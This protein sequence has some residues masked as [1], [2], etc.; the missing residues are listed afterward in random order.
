MRGDL[1]QVAQL[2]TADPA[3]ANFTTDNGITPLHCAAG[4]GYIDVVRFLV[5]R[6]GA[7]V[8]CKAV[9]GATSLHFA[10]LNRHTEIARFLLRHGADADASTRQHQRPIHLAVRWTSNPDMRDVIAL[11]IQC[12]AQI[13]VYVNIAIA[14]IDDAI[15]AI[16]PQGVSSQAYLPNDLL[17]SAMLR[18]SLQ[19]VEHLLMC[20]ADPNAIGSWKCTP[21]SF[22]IT[23]MPFQDASTRKGVIAALEKY[24]AAT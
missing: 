12:R 20:G 17:P 14:T 1:E 18:Q 7:D 24:N 9:D 4:D 15:I 8:N 6:G 13:D 16:T 5:E 11:L 2:V 10:L 19:L 22:A 23:Q 21:L 3:L